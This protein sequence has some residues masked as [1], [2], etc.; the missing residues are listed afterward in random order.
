MNKSVNLETEQMAVVAL[1]LFVRG[2]LTVRALST[3][4]T[5]QD[6]IAKNQRTEESAHVP[7]LFIT[8]FL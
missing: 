8:F 1:S 3:G 5:A 2:T 7:L 6:I 4:P